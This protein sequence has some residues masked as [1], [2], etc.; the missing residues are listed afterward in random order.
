LADY[1]K[2]RGEYMNINPEPIIHG[3]RKTFKNTQYWDEMQ[4]VIHLL[5][6]LNGIEM[7]C[8]IQQS[9]IKELEEKYVKLPKDEALSQP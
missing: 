3:L 7:I 1:G 5:Q 4:I 2:G 9:Y 8:S 6:K